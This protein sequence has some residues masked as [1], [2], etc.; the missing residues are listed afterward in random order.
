MG[1]K[2]PQEEKSFTEQVFDIVKRIPCGCVS[3]YGQV[4]RLMGRPR[5]ARYV[6]FA[7]R[8]NP[9]PHVIPCHRVLFSD[10]SLCKGYEFG[11]PEVQRHLLEEEG[12]EFLDDTH[13]D[14]ERFQWKPEFDVLGR[15][16]DIDWKAEMGED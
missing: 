6:G 5:S 15:P 8:R 1:E 2:E 9:Q 12:I 14:L 11:G 16:A 3:T 4:A 7:L 10:G 13:V